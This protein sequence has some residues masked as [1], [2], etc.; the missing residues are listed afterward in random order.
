[1][2]TYSLVGINPTRIIHAG[3]INGQLPSG[4]PTV[5]AGLARYSGLTAGGL[6]AFDKKSIIVEELSGTFA[7]V[8]SSGSTIRST[9]TSFPFKLYPGEWLKASSG[10]SVA[11]VVRL[12]AQRIL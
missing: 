10:S 8:D 9:P 12:D 4:E 7:I 3:T 2:K 11:C 1:M 5:S 6:F